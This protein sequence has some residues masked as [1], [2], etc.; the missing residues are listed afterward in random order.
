MLTLG[1]FAGDDKVPLVL[2]GVVEATAPDQ[3]AQ[4]TR[5]VVH[6][7]LA[8]ARGVYRRP[9]D[10]YWCFWSCDPHPDCGPQ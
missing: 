10:P 3:V 7:M 8:N 2:R 9:I 5:E 4:L 6:E 1:V